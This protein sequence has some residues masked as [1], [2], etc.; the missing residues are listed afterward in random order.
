MTTASSAK[1]QVDWDNEEARKS[2]VDSRA[3]DAYAALGLLE[4]RQLAEDVK[5]AA[6]LLASV[7]GQDLEQVEDGSVRVARRVAKD[8]IIST[9]DPEARHGRKTQAH[10]FDGWKGHIAADPDSEII[11]NTTVTAGN[12]GDAGAAPSLLEDIATDVPEPG[13]DTAEQGSPVARRQ[14]GGGRKGHRGDKKANKQ[15]AHA[16]RRAEHAT[17]RQAKLRSRK[18]AAPPRAEEATPAVYGDTAYGA[19][20]LLAYLDENGI[21]PRVKVQ[22]PVAPGGLFPKDRFKIDLAAGTVTCP[23]G[24]TVAISF[25]KAGDGTACFSDAC[26]NCPLR[27]S[28]TTATAGRTI[29]I[30]PHEELL[31]AQRERCADPSFAADYRATRPKVERI[32]AHLM[33]R[34]HG[35]RRARVRGRRKVDADFNLLAA[36]RNLARLA[37]LGLRSTPTA[38]VAAGT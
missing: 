20:D 7:L 33:L 15:A 37:V 26:N 21:D 12:K 6:E 11:T 14:A 10:A 35:G 8:R 9:V 3:K 31:Q 19:G 34:R 30:S 1:P 18:A 27:Q 17:R 36:S 2:L 13:D 23:A 4:G 38:W 32:L 16:A 29:S 28:C 22:P 5:E 25:G 24:N